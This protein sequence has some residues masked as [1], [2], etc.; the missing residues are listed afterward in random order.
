MICHIIYIKRA[1]HDITDFFI[2]GINLIKRNLNHHQKN[3]VRYLY[4]SYDIY[5]NHVLKSN[6]C[7][8]VEGS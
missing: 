3:D 1:L 5:L 2:K 4:K 6:Y 8:H 7:K